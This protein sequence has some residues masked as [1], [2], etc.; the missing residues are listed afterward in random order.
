MKAQHRAHAMQLGHGK[1]SEPKAQVREGDIVFQHVD[2]GGHGR[3]N[4]TL[5]VQQQLGQRS[6]AG[7]HRGQGCGTGIANLVP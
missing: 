2:Q 1:L 5:H 3:N 4:R 6:I 7:Q